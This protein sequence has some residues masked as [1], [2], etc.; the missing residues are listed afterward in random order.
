MTHN[1]AAVGHRD[2]SVNRASKL[3]T[4]QT[5]WCVHCCV[6]GITSHYC[7]PQLGGARILSAK[8][9]L[10]ERA[11]EKIYR[12]STMNTLSGRHGLQPGELNNAKAGNKEAA[13]ILKRYRRCLGFIT[14]G[15]S[16]HDDPSWSEMYK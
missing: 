9:L 4:R 10:A 14:V 2:H 3:D 6:T 8:D 11:R 7:S 12:G 5:S 16:G 1:G 15:I 13:A